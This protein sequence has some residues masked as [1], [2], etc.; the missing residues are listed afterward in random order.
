M[1]F[2]QARACGSCSQ[3]LH[4]AEARGPSPE[5]N[6]AVLAANAPFAS[7]SA[8]ALAGVPGPFTTRSLCAPGSVAAIN[9]VNESASA[10]TRWATRPV[11]PVSCSMSPR[12]AWKCARQTLSMSTS[13]FSKKVLTVS[14][15]PFPPSI[16]GRSWCSS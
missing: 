12:M 14:G 16:E 1:V 2:S 4:A 8:F 3:T 15:S 7:M 10:S 5:G 9:T 6:P 13:N 11:L